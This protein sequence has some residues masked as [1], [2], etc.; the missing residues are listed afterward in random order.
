MTR[1]L[2]GSFF[3]FAIIFILT[4]PIQPYPGSVAVKAVPAVC[5][6]LLCL[7]EVKGLRG[8]LL[9]LAF[10]LCASGDAVLSLDSGRHF[11]AGLVLFLLAQ[12]TFLA[13]FAMDFGPRRGKVP[14][15]AILIVYAA[16]MGAILRPYLGDMVLP[17]YA[18]LSVITAMGI[19]ASL[20]ATTNKKVITGAIIFIASDSIIAVNK[21]AASVPAA[22]YLVMVTYYA[23]LFLIATGFIRERT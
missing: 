12:L 21:F 8:R 14:V 9:F 23:A 2:L 7:S 13:T 18:Y 19:M 20:R 17:V 11:I 5:L 3:L 4:I 10:L 1:N 16:V 15:A 22:D 6:A